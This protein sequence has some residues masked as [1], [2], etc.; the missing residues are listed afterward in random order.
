MLRPF[1]NAA[2]AAALLA[3]VLPKADAAELLYVFEPGCPY[4]RLWDREIAPIYGRTAEGEKATLIAIDRRDPALAGLKLA[5]PV[6]YAPT[7][8]LM[9]NGAELGRI[10]GY[11]GEDFFWGRLAGLLER[12]PGTDGKKAT[13]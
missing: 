11:Q 10:E 12:L 8:V 5:G 4:C 2:L 13:N 6:R 7:F 9:E 1:V 3:I